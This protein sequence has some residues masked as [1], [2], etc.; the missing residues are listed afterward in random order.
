MVAGLAAAAR[1]VPTRIPHLGE[2]MPGMFAVPQNPVLDAMASV[3][4]V[5]PVAGAGMSGLGCGCVSGLCGCGGSGSGSGMSGLGF[6]LQT[7]WDSVVTT[8]SQPYLGVP[9]WGWGLGAVAVLMLM[10]PGGSDYRRER[11]ALRSKYR[12]YRRLAGYAS[13]QLGQVA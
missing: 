5:K 11:R 3:N 12:G 7:T 2:L 9:L 8:A 1:G 13:D 4:V 10:S 6:D